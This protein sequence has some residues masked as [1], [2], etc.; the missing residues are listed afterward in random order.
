VLVGD[1]R[2]RRGAGDRQRADI[3]EALAGRRERQHD[4]VADRHDEV[5][6]LAHSGLPQRVDGRDRGPGR[7]GI[8]HAAR[9]EA[10]VEARAARVVVGG[11]DVHAAAAE[12]ADD[13]DGAAAPGVGDQHARRH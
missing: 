8:A 7:V 9:G 3:F 13:G 6:R 10:G 12:R 11:H 1:R 4:L 5:E 2:Q